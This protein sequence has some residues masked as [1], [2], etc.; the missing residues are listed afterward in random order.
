MPQIN[1]NLAE[2]K[3]NLL[4]NVSNVMETL[5]LLLFIQ[6]ASGLQRR[7]WVSI[8]SRTVE[9]LAATNKIFDYFTLLIRFV[10]A[11][12][13]LQFLISEI[14]TAKPRMPSF[15]TAGMAVVSLNVNNY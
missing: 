3:M 4:F 6:V 15:A 5:L 13:D 14:K 9:F 11:S 8:S 1:L 12:F 7:L 10:S 2:L